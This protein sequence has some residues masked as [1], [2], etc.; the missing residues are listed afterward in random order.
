MYFEVYTC[1]CPPLPSPPTPRLPVGMKPVMF[2]QVVTPSPSSPPLPAGVKPVAGGDRPAFLGSHLHVDLL[3]LDWHHLRGVAQRDREQGQ[4]RPYPGG[5]GLM[6]G[7][8]P[9]PHDQLQVCPDRATPV[10]H[11][12]HPD[13]L[14]RLPLHHRLQVKKQLAAHPWNFFFVVGGGRGGGLHWAV[15]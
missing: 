1:K 5:C 3:H 8:A 4:E 6:D 15:W 14:Q 11:Q 13:L 2:L 10:V 12:L 7:V 9:G